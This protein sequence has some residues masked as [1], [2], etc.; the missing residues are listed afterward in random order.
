MVTC[1]IC[2]MKD[3][4]LC[5]HCSINLKILNMTIPKE[6]DKKCLLCSNQTSDTNPYCNVH[7][8]IKNCGRVKFS[9]FDFCRYCKCCVWSCL[10]PATKGFFC[11]NHCCGTKWCPYNKDS[12][13]LF[14]RNCRI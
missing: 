10:F 3:T 5:E 13:D 1:Y 11:V 12:E 8:C 2:G 6:L 4:P 14:C 9:N 7:G